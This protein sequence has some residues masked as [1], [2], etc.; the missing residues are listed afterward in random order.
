MSRIY[1]YDHA[2]ASGGVGFLTLH[3]VEDGLAGVFVRPHGRV[4]GGS[5]LPTH[6][7]GLLS[8]YKGMRRAGGTRFGAGSLA[9]EIIFFDRGEPGVRIGA[10]DHAEFVGIDAEFL[11]E[12]EAILQR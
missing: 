9:E 10:T 6:D 7:D 3:G 8:L 11:F 5:L 4:A 1:A 12:L 2:W